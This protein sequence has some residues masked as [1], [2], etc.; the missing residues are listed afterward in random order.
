[1]IEINY[2]GALAIGGLRP[3]VQVRDAYCGSRRFSVVRRETPPVQ[4][5][6]S[7]LVLPI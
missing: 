3:L 4:I 6:G 1:M 2:F 7:V 5:K